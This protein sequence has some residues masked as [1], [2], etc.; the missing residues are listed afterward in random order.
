M[1][2]MYKTVLLW[3]NSYHVSIVKS[4]GIVLFNNCLI[5]R[6]VSRLRVLGRS[7]NLVSILIPP[8]TTAVINE[9][10]QPKYGSD[11]SEKNGRH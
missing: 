1:L 5:S 8:S 10:P 4:I 9:D 7:L 11:N 6:V 2:N 3:L